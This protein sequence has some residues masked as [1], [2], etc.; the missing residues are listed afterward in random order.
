[1]LLT[2]IQFGERDRTL[3]WYFYFIPNIKFSSLVWRVTKTK[4][5]FPTDE[6][7]KKNEIH[8]S[9]YKKNWVLVFLN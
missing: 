2:W 7:K 5:N 8:Y 9:I 4:Q 6:K 3:E 1:M